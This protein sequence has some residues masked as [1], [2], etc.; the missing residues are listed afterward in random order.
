VFNEQELKK[1]PRSRNLIGSR[2]KFINNPE[3]ANA[4]SAVHYTWKVVLQLEQ[5]WGST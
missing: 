5:Q 1:K 2:A 4:L 3:S